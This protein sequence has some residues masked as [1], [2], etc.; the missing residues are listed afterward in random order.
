VD[1]SSVDYLHT[2]LLIY[3]DRGGEVISGSGFII[4]RNTGYAVSSNDHIL[5]VESQTCFAEY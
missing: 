4:E 1:V 2:A 3:C 5:G